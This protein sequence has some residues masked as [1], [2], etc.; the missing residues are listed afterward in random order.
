[1]KNYPIYPAA[2]FEN[3]FDEMFERVEKGETIGILTTAGD[4]V[5]MLPI[6]ETTKEL[7]TLNEN[8]Q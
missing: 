8:K 4:V 2:E 6:D 1:M 5:L 7:L 3:R